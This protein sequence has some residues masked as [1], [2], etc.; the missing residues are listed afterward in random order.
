MSENNNHRHR[1]DDEVSDDEAFDNFEVTE[2]LTRRIASIL[3]DYA[4][5][6]QIARE[7]LQNSEDAG[8]T[9]QWYLLD[10]RTH[11]SESIFRKGLEEYMGPALLAGNNS[12]FK[13]KDFQSLM[14]LANSGKKG[15]YEKIG[16][17]GIGFNRY[18]K[19]YS[20]FY[21]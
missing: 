21:S 7:L 6:P 1:S 10:H 11:P 17:M 18:E 8:S 3:N 15:D 4:D 13:E 9:K 16:Q 12:S 19:I 2:P 5:G 20:F 14:N